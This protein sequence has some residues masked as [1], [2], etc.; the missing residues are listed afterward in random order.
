MVSFQQ[1]YHAIFPDQTVTFFSEEERD[2]FVSGNESDNHFVVK[3]HSFILKSELER[4]Q[5]WPNIPRPLEHQPLPPVLA[6]MRAVPGPIKIGD[7]VPPV[8]SV[9][10]SLSISVDRSTLL[11]L[12]RWFHA[13]AGWISSETREGLAAHGFVRLLEATVKPTEEELRAPRVQA[14]DAPRTSETP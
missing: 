13:D 12:I 6:S 10:E 9:G 5:D 11:L 2:S 4:I 14:E 1:I 8:P 7:S 3:A